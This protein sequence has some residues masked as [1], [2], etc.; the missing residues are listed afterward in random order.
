MNKMEAKNTVIKYLK[1]RNIHFYEHVS[2]GA[3]SLVLAL[4][5]YDRC[6]NSELECC[7]YFYRTCLEAR[8]Y[9]TE[10]ASQWIAERPERL[11]DMYRLL[12][13]IGARVW[14]FN[15]DGI[16]GE[17]YS[18]H[19]LVTPRIYITEDGYY[20][21]TSTMLID[22][23]IFDMAPLEVCD[24][25]TVS[26]PALMDELSTPLFSVLLEKL[27]LDDAISYIKRELLE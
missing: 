6:P 25:I 19:H 24:T 11:S 10:S 17:L 5:G 18:A 2:E 4:P 3:G 23:D 12:N 8:V 14:P 15:H 21:L 1:E 16:G 20:D 22:Y 7:F 13:F 9:Y 26:I 27:N